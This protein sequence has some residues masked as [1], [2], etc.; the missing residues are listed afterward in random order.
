MLKILIRSRDMV[1]NGIPFISHEIAVLPVKRYSPSESIFWTLLSARPG[2]LVI[3]RFQPADHRQVERRTAP[4]L[5]S[6][7]DGCIAWF[8]AD[9]ANIR[10][11]LASWEVE[12][13][14]EEC[15]VKW[16]G[17]LLEWTEKWGLQ[18]L[19]LLQDCELI[20]HVTRWQ[21]LPKF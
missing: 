8:E 12:E 16:R 19:C 10:S 6:M 9:H 5:D 7:S 15:L 3:L 1:V 2:Q 17:K 13:E 14:E 18:V 20:E 21:W 11:N 4:G